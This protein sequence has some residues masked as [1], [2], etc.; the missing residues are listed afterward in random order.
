MRCLLVVA[1]VAAVALAAFDAK[2]QT[3]L[4]NPASENCV[5]KGGRIAIEKN[6]RGGEYGV[7][8]FADNLQCEEWAMMRGQCKSGGIRVTGFVTPAARYCAITGGRYKVASA[9]NTPQEQGTCGFAGGSTCDAAAYFD[10]SCVRET[11]AASK[12]IIAR[13]NCVGGR[14]IGATFV[15]GANSHVDLVL[16][17]GRK[18]TLPQ[19]MSGSGAR[20]ANAD[21]SFVFWNKGD[22]AFIEESGKTTYDGCRTKA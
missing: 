22:T 19:A 20:Y 2:G 9:G 13:F 5:A 16:S 15:N 17:D 6:P 21:E 12:P 3:R 4:A 14:W 11:A 10:G 18:L 8:V 7:C 1:A